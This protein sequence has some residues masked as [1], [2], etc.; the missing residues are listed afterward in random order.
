[1]NQ[2]PRPDLVPG[3]QWNETTNTTE[4][5]RQPVTY[6]QAPKPCDVTQEDVD[7]FVRSLRNRGTPF[8]DGVADLILKLWASRQ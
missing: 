4:T 6:T 7:C 2:L 8:D 1:M 3:F 5:I